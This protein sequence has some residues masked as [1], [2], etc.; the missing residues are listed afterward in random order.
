MGDRIV[1]SISRRAVLT[2]V[3][4]A[5]LSHNPAVASNTRIAVPAKPEPYVFDGS[6]A[7]VIVVDMQ[8]DFGAKGGLLD[9]QGI[10]ISIVQKA[11]RPTAKVLTAARQKGIRVLYLKMGYLPDLSDLGSEDSP[12]RIRSLQSG[13]G[14]EVRAPDGRASR[15]LIRDTW[16]TDILAELKPFPSD[17]VIY[18]TRFS[19]FYRTNLDDTLK[20]MGM[21]YLLIVGCTTSVCVES[22]VRD[23][24]FRDYRCLVMADCTG[25]PY[26]YG[27]ARSNHEAS[28]LLIESEFGWVSH[29]DDLVKALQA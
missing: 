7:A 20:R 21:K 16:N 13:V 6:K 8:N 3:A 5:A 1:G 9:R 4:S 27:L 19:G 11:I 17:T 22:T 25:E 18:K 29:S 15:I 10:D 26:G 2:G 23:A 28:L 14:T 12:N 24:M